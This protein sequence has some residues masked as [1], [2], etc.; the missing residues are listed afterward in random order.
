MC[1]H[2]YVGKN[3]KRK[4]ERKKVMR[5][6]KKKKTKRARRGPIF[7]LGLKQLDTK[8]SVYDFTKLKSENKKVS[9]LKYVI[10]LTF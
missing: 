6:R 4:N 9:I 3:S 7:C 2:K 10:L 5:M 8:M 1:L